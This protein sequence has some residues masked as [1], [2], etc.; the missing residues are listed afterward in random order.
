MIVSDKVKSFTEYAY[1][2]HD[3]ASYLFNAI[4]EM[5][6]LHESHFMTKKNKELIREKKALQEELQL[7]K[8]IGPSIE[9][10]DGD[11]QTQ[12][13]TPGQQQHK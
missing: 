10:I 11:K 8:S 12:K 1:A 7:A 3:Q 5:K 2:A 13:Q 4:N 9:S 6:S